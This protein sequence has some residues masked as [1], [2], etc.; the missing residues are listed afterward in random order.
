MSLLSSHV[1]KVLQEK[2]QNGSQ[3]IACPGCC[4]YCCL[5]SHQHCTPSTLCLAMLDLFHSSSLPSVISHPPGMLVPMSDQ[6]QLLDTPVVNRQINYW[7]THCFSTTCLTHELLL[8]KWLK[9]REGGVM[10]KETEEGRE[11]RVGHHQPRRSI[12]QPVDLGWEKHRISQGQSWGDVSCHR[13]GDLRPR[14][15]P[16]SWVLARGLRP[17]KSQM[18]Q[19]GG[20]G[21]HSLRTVAGPPLIH[22]LSVQQKGSPRG[23]QGWNWDWIDP[24]QFIG[25]T[26]IPR[27]TSR[28]HQLALQPEVWCHSGH[29]DLRKLYEDT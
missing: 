28:S 20:G 26:L 18:V 2:V 12:P 5:I 24:K 9:E 11:D 15:V 8:S 21:S 22:T 3:D 16:L 19:G 7:A 17:P 6:W 13:L 25:L 14:P 10:R 4:L 29:P 27:A 1:P 23:G